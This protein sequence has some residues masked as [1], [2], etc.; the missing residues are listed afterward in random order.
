MQPAG[1][2]FFVSWLEQALFGDG[3]GGK[4]IDDHLENA[5][6]FFAHVGFLVMIARV[7]QLGQL[8]WR[9][10]N[11]KAFWQRQVLSS[12]SGICLYFT[13]FL[14]LLPVLIC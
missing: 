9:K 7:T 8:L 6:R 12:V 10:R 1:H 11:G 14:P 4:A 5:R 13:T 2:G 3:R